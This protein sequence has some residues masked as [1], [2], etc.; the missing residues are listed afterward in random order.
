MRETMIR[1]TEDQIERADRYAANMAKRMG[2]RVSRSDVCRMALLRLLDAE[3][4]EES[5]H[6]IEEKATKAPKGKST[7]AE[8]AKA[9]AA[10][11]VAESVLTTGKPVRSIGEPR[12]FAGINPNADLDAM[13]NPFL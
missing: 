10:R 7:K 8:D 1:L 2:L 5:P 12:D 3:G 11:E 13:P 6:K 4:V 9:K